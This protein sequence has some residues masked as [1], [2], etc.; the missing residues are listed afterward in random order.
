[1]LLAHPFV[2]VLQSQNGIIVLSVLLTRIGDYGHIA[3]FMVVFTPPLAEHIRFLNVGIP[4]L[5]QSLQREFLIKFIPVG[6]M[7]LP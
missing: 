7:N 4:D 2:Y 5:A 1:M 6:G 3:V